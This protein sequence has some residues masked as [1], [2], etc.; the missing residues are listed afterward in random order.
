[1]SA[2]ATFRDMRAKNSWRDVSSGGGGTHHN[3]SIA[4]SNLRNIT[5][6]HVIRN[7]VALDP[8]FIIVHTYDTDKTRA[9]MRGTLHVQL[10][11]V[12]LLLLSGKVAI[13]GLSLT[14]RQVFALSR[15]V[16]GALVLMTASG[17]ITDFSRSAA[18][19]ADNSDVDGLVQ[20]N[21]KSN[22]QSTITGV[23]YRDERIGKGPVVLNKDVVVMHLQGQTR[24]GNV[25]VD[26]RNQGKPILHQIGSVTDY[27]FF[28]GKSSR[29]PI[30]TIGIEDGLRGMKEGGIRRIVVPGPLGYGHAGVSRYDAMQ[31]GLLNPIPRDEIL[32]FEVELLRCVDV[33]I[34][35]DGD[36]NDRSNGVELV[37]QACCSEPDYPCKTSTNENQ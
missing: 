18:H 21:P 28:G 3:L 13:K 26:T 16:G 1:M 6:D 24:S 2:E 30:V 35:I 14:R 12:L 27:D 15:D 32:A 9:N 5:N 20:D 7:H 29:R 11:I 33:P 31:M 34:R 23:Q 10:V 36:D 25:I 8:H 17:G 22:I 19:A 37:A 4:R